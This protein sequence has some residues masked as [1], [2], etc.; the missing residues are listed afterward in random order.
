MKKEYAKR[1]LKS[2]CYYK[3]QKKT[4]FIKKSFDSFYFAL[5]YDI[6]WI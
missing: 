4:E 2:I 5:Y 6:N 1:K 3:L